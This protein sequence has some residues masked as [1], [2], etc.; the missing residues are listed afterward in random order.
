MH[1]LEN[2]NIC[3]IKHAGKSSAANAL[4]ELL[5][6]SWIDSDDILREEY[7]YTA[8]TSLS[9]REI[10]R[11]LGEEGFRKF[12]AEIL[13]KLWEYDEKGIIALGG[14]ALS[15]P[16]LTENDLKNAGMI[17]CIDVPDRIAFDRIMK[18]GVPPFL[19]QAE[20]PFA[21]FQEMNRERRSFFEK[22][23]HLVIHADGQS[24]PYS[25]AEEII[26]AC[27]KRWNNKG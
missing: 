12:E 21:S 15:N 3:G 14:G 19:Q 4:G 17:V 25:N 27:E 7:N 9:V 26:R 23:A 11:K 8:G 5:K 22:M 13:R 18:K 6:V 24:S 16:F 20:D 10:Y 1:L 2:I